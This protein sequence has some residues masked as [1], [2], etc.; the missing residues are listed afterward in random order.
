MMVPALSQIMVVSRDP[1]VILIYFLAFR[2]KLFPATKWFALWMFLGV[3]CLF[4]ALALVQV[5]LQIALYGFRSLFLHIPIL[6]LFPVVFK[7]EHI[8]A[9]VRMLIVFA[10]FNALLMVAQYVQ[11]PDS[12]LNRGVSKEFAQITAAGDKTR[13]PGTFTFIVGP[14]TFF[15]IFFATLLFQLRRERTWI[16]TIGFA[17]LVVATAV[18]SSRGLAIGLAITAVFYLIGAQVSRQITLMQVCQYAVA[19]VGITAVALSIGP[20]AEGAE[21]FQARAE[22]ANT[23]EG[24][25]RGVFNRAYDLLASAFRAAAFADPLGGGLGMGSNFASVALGGRRA[26]PFAEAEWPRMVMELGP[27]LGFIYLFMRVGLVAAALSIAWSAVK[28]GFAGPLAVWAAFAPN[29]IAGNMHQSTL[30][31]IAVFGGG[32]TLWFSKVGQ[33]PPGESSA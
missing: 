12:V 9:F 23:S 17:A 8:T 19:L 13:P 31:G 32:L 24:G 21:T 22:A 1:I 7:E 28:R 4:V 30:L 33:N 5:P 3:I 26:F 15:P 20:I 18:S 25:A 2:N 11:G 10:C 29:L 14:S 16:L 6:L 27:G